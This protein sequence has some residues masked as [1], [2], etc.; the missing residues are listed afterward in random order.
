MGEIILG[1]ENGE[2]V[3][4]NHPCII[5]RFFTLFGKERYA[6]PAYLSERKGVVYGYK[7]LWGAKFYTGTYHKTTT[8]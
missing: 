6:E 2:Y 4:L 7:E 8:K 5:E 3:A 1:I